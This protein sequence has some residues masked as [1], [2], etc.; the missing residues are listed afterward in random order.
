MEYTWKMFYCSVTKSCLTLW[1]PWTAAL[2]A[3]LSITIFQNLFKL[4]SIESLMPSI[5]LNLC[6]PLSSCPQSFPTSGSFPV[7]QLFKSGGQSIGASASASVLP[8]NIQGW[9]LLGLI[10]LIPLL[11]KGL[12]RVFFNTTIWKHQFFSAELSLWSS[13]NMQRDINLM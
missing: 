1:P 6:C 12:S 8:V 10:G 4:M 13:S 3:S 9:F 7:G 11:S 5:H 2:H